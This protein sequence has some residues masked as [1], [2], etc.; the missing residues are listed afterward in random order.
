MTF[1]ELGETVPALARLVALCGDVTA[2]RE[3]SRALTAR[4]AETRAVRAVRLLAIRA[5]V[6]VRLPRPGKEIPR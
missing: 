2:T 6:S 4:P 3:R 1:H 5:G